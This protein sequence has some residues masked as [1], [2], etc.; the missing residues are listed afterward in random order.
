M[1][2]LNIEELR[3]QFIALFYMCG[4]ENEYNWIYID[5]YN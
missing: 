2:Y 1:E 4:L 5:V 3:E